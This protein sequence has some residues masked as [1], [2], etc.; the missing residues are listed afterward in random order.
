[1]AEN[2]TQP[3]SNTAQGLVSDMEAM[4]GR[5][6][7]QMKEE[8]VDELG[9]A[10]AA[11]ASLGGGLSMAALGTILGGLAFVHLMHKV[12]GW[13]LWFCYAASSA[14]A[15]ATSAGLVAEGVR[16][17]GK[18]DFIPAETGRVARDVASRAAEHVG[19]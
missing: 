9:K 19:R 13:P 2:A 1:M 15:C 16:Q 14:A 11:G 4:L 18:L 17:A 6:L 3:L 5:R 8:V 7:G 12:T 10:T